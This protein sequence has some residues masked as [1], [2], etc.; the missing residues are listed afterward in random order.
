M[1][2]NSSTYSFLSNVLPVAELD[3]SVQCA[4]PWAF[5]VDFSL[6]EKN[7]GNE[8]YCEEVYFATTHDAYNDVEKRWR[9]D[10]VHIKADLKSILLEGMV[11]CLDIENSRTS[12]TKKNRNIN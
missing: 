4:Y 8:V 10:F 2:N 5:I 6:Q 1:G 3:E 7:T 11:I 12:I 9:H